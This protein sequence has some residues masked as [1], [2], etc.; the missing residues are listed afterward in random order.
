MSRPQAAQRTVVVGMSGGVDSSVAA[1]RV[2]STGAKVVGVSLRLLTEGANE[3]HDAGIAAAA[4][5][6]S[7]LGIE[8]HVIDA[9]RFFDSNVLQYVADEYASGLTPNP[10]T[11]CN[12]EVKFAL[13]VNFADEIGADK[14]VT[15]HYARILNEGE[16][17]W[18]G[19]A[20]DR[21]KDQ[22]YFLY[23]LGSKVLARLE[24][25]LGECSKE[26][27]RQEAE[28]I[29]I[30]V[31]RR[32][33]SQDVCFALDGDVAGFVAGRHPSVTQPGPIVLDGEVVGTHKGIGRYTV[34]QRKGLGIGGEGPYYVIKI[35]ALDAS[36]HV[37][38]GSDVSHNT[39]RTENVVWR[40]EVDSVDCLIQVRH[41]MEP[42]EAHVTVVDGVMQVSSEVG[43]FAPAPG[44]SVVCYIG[45]RVIGGGEMCPL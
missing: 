35:D 12:E 13:L 24:F 19:R 28:E 1:H 45:D 38:R 10:C 16:S 5:V 31:A 44:Q 42:V 21:E 41:R 40:W 8:H 7:E 26:D 43:I 23:R 17:D 4:R 25:P 34:G 39:V 33:E 15:G 2:L 6:A 11:R 32:P 20:I 30:H 29:G 18:I 3:S 27:V 14:V 9:T 37:R 22:S 36:V